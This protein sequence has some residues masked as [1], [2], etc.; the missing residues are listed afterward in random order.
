MKMAIPF[1]EVPFKSSRPI[2]Q[3]AM[4]DAG[5]FTTF[6]PRLNIADDLANAGSVR[7]TNDY[8]RAFE[9]ERIGLC[10][11]LLSPDGNMCS[12]AYPEVLPERMELVAYTTELGF[13]HDGR[14]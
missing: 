13:I 2:S 6:E 11:A 5:C 1:S 12:L 8:A 7:A 14:L 3:N 4:K 10:P 9:L